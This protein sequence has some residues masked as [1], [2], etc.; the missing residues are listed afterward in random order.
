MSAE[1]LRWNAEKKEAKYNSKCILYYLKASTVHTV[2]TVSNVHT[3][4]HIHVYIQVHMPFMGTLN[5]HSTMSCVLS[6]ELAPTPL[7]AVQVMV[8]KALSL[9]TV[10]ALRVLVTLKVASSMELVMTSA[11]PSEIRGTPFM[12]QEMVGAGTPV[13]VHISAPEAPSEMFAAGF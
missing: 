2:H 11:A 10:V 7:D 1:M 12:N 8:A 9:V 13:A 6:E 4:I 3:Y 5:L